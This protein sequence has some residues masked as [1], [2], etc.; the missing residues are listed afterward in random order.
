M[1]LGMRTAALL[2]VLSCAAPALAFMAPGSF[3]PVRG[4]L[5]VRI[6]VE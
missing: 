1:A 2:S 4:A 6:L 5:Q 3:A